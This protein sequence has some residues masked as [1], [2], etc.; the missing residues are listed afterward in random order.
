VM[1]IWLYLLIPALPMLM[2]PALFLPGLGRR[3]LPLA[4]WVPTLTL[5][6][7]PYQG[8]VFE[9]PWLLLGARLGMDAYGLP[10]MLLA[11][12]AWTL[13]GWH[14]R[15]TLPAERQPAFFLFWLL[16]WCGNSC[17]FLTLDAASFYA[18]YALMTFSAYGLVVH[19]GRP[20][21]F[22]AGRVYLTMAVLGEA[23]LIGGLLLLAA[24]V[25]NAPLELAPQLVADALRGPWIAALM[26][27]GFGVKMG[28]VGLHMWLPLAHPQAPVPASAVLS[29]VIIKAGLMG[30]L[31][32]LPLG[33]EA[34]AW[35]GYGPVAGRRA[36]PPLS[37]ARQ[38]GLA[39]Q[40]GQGAA[41]LFQHQS[42]GAGGLLDCAGAVAAGTS[43][44]VRSFGGDLCATSWVGEVLPVPGCG[45]G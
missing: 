32:F 31:R 20:E 11:I 16:T 25:G 12:T 44:S 45:P 38:L 23:L 27:A 15:R 40:Q 36:E 2:A 41:G 17:V 5:L 19:L 18:A 30:W 37:M 6:L 29:G 26:L 14:A 35:L 28:L 24:E 3:L 43:F 39:Q 1:G 8:A 13:A 7:L 42:D 4:P 10:L 22:R 34:Y 33:S 9:L 21:D